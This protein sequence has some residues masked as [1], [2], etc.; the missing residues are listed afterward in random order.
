MWISYKL[1][2]YEVCHAHVKINF[3]KNAHVNKIELW[4]YETRVCGA[5]RIQNDGWAV[6]CTGTYS[7]TTRRQISW[8]SRQP[9]QSHRAWKL[10]YKFFEDISEKCPEGVRNAT[11][12]EAYCISDLIQHYRNNGKSCYTYG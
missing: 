8:F 7:P 9:W 5:Y 1:Y 12:E 3:D 11:D 2:N 6:F 4:S 10:S